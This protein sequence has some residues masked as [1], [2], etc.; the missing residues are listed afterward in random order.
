METKNLE[1]ALRQFG[2]E[3]VS[4]LVKEL[5][6]AD[7]DVTGNLIKSI[8][9]E[10]VEKANTFMLNIKALDYLKYVD[11]GRRPGAKQ[12]PVSAII[13]WVKRKGI[14]IGKTPE[15]TAFVIA[16]SIKKNGI[17]PTNV[18]SKAIQTTMR[19]KMDLLAKHAVEDIMDFI[20]MTLK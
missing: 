1:K 12:P 16:K 2:D 13:P 3:L 18:I 19:T 9:Y 6:Q 11:G 10:L 4:N 8:D 5:I 20:D 7:K 17:K 14:K 15:Q